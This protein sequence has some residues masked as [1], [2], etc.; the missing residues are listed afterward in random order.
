MSRAHLLNAL[1]AYLQK[2][3]CL[4]STDVKQHPHTG[5]RTAKELQDCVH[6]RVLQLLPLP[7]D[8]LCH[9]RL[10]VGAFDDAQVPV[11]SHPVV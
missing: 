5:T 8:V 7:G 1:H 10:D 3:V 2:Q 6:Q 9:P 11:D 4:P